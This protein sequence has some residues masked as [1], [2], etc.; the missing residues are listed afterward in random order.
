MSTTV[1]VKEGLVMLGSKMDIVI[2][3]IDTLMEIV[4]VLKQRN[5][6]LE[7]TITHA[8]YFL[9]DYNNDSDMGTHAKRVL[10]NAMSTFKKES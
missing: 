8:H 1:K 10:V 3:N 2:D 6:L 4:R 7:N 5:T 9:K